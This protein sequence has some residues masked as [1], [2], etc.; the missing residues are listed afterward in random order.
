MGLIGEHDNERRLLFEQMLDA[1]ALHDVIRDEQDRAVDYRLIEI[2]P[3]YERITGKSEKEVVGR[4]LRE[5]FPDLEPE[6]Y[7]TFREVVESGKPVRFTRYTRALD[8]YL[9]AAAYRPRKGSYAISFRDVTPRERARHELEQTTDL[10]RKVLTGTVDMM[11]RT[12]EIRDPYTAGHQRRVAQLARAM[13]EEMGLSEQRKTA[14]YLGALAHD[15]GKIAVPSEILN[16]PGRLEPLQYRIVQSHPGIGADIL[17]TVP[18][19]WPLSAIVH[20]HHE[21][22]DGS[23][24]PEGLT[25]D[26]IL[27]EARIV[28][29]ADVVESMCSH[30]PYRAALPHLAGLRE[31]NQHKGDS[32]DPRVVRTCLSL[33]ERGF[34]FEEVHVPTVE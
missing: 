1:Y 10:L 27:L 8:K 15:I 24:Y 18:F 19:P 7:D 4:T 28:A 20:Q 2:N 25:G 12:T 26:D 30:R 23:G 29:V 17:G 21:R 16:R 9:E 33:F 6:W 5:A 32:Y 13:A 14:T 34:K 3:A 22:M 31:I 11:G